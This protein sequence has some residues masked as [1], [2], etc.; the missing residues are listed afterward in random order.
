MIIMITK[1]DLP[2]FMIIY[3]IFLFGFGHL[4]YIASN[5][6]HAGVHEGMD[7]IYRTFT[8]GKVFLEC[9][10]HS[11]FLPI[12]I[13]PDL[14]KHSVLAVTG[15]IDTGKEDKEVKDQPALL[16]ITAIVCLSNF[17]F[18]TIVLMNLLIAMLS[19]TYEQISR[20]ARQCWKLH[21]LRI[22]TKIDRG[23]SRAERTRV[24][25]VFWQT[26]DSSKG[27]RRC[28]SRLVKLC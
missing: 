3:C 20:E 9:S 14:S 27:K 5:N 21:R 2:I 1:N 17:F 18:V 11:Y 4:H 13:S 19:N 15:N 25:R 22:L 28:V 8:A 12:A 16:Y 26:T 23:L 7:S 6:L 10:I 24:D